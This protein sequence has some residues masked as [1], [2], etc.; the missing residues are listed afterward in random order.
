MANSSSLLR[1]FRTDHVRIEQVFCSA[2][3]LFGSLP[4]PLPKDAHLDMMYETSDATF[5]FFGRCLGVPELRVFQAV[6]AL[7]PVS[8]PGGCKML[9]DG[10]NEY[11]VG[12]EHLRTLSVDDH[13]FDGDS[14]VVRTTF[15]ELAKECGYA[16]SCF[17]GGARIKAVQKALETLWSVTV[18]IRHNSGDV[19]GS[20]LLSH[21]QADKSGK[22]TVAINPRLAEGIMGKR[23]Y[24]RLD[25]NEIRA[26]KSDPARLINQRVCGFIDPGKSHKVALDTLIG[27]VWLS[28]ALNIKAIQWRK[29][30]VRK[31]LTE[32]EVLGWSAAEYVE[33]KFD[34]SRRKMAN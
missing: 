15:Y 9:L 22:L 28:Q 10:D 8:G 20:R 31:A 26:L 13:K 18:L 12:K 30:A 34:I 6:L 33:D 16:D 32:L 23:R 1:L 19:D 3:G 2:P 21:Y 25:M 4:K 27:Y 11:A 7:V 17:H 29:R 5:E 14:L 24:S